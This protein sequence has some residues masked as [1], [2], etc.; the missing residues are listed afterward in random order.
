M[1][2]L[3]I[4]MAMYK[5]SFLIFDLYFVGQ[6]FCKLMLSLLFKA[7]FDGFPALGRYIPG[8]SLVS[9]FFLATPESYEHK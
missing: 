6:L 1:R 9:V 4:I 8:V 5:I 7:V 3:C 2:L